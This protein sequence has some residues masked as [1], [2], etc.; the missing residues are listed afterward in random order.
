MGDIE[1]TNNRFF[2]DRAEKQADGI[3]VVKIDNSLATAVFNQHDA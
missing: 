3:V 1:G 2:T